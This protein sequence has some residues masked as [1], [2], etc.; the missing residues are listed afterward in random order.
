M[1]RWFEHAVLVIV[2]ILSIT[3]ISLF[4]VQYQTL[5]RAKSDLISL[6]RDTGSNIDWSDPYWANPYRS[7]TKYVT[8]DS[9]ENV[10]NRALACESKVDGCTQTQKALEEL[11]VTSTRYFALEDGV[12]LV[13]ESTENGPDRLY[14]LVSDARDGNQDV[15]GNVL[16]SFPVASHP[17]GDGGF[18][19]KR[20]SNG[21]YRLDV[22]ADYIEAGE[23]T[24]GYINASAKRFLTVSSASFDFG[25]TLRTP[26]I[27]RGVLEPHL[28]K[29]DCA[30]SSKATIDGILWNGNL[31]Y[32]F[33]K[34]IQTK[35]TYIEL[36]G[37]NIIDFFGQ[38]MVPPLN[39]SSIDIPLKT[40]G[41]L[42]VEF[43]GG[44]KPNFSLR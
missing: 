4:V 41:R 20:L 23:S 29:D 27:E 31:E 2:S 38:E 8:R 44:N 37:A 17:S 16:G 33:A 32:R 39:L 42:H 10:F 1:K 9:Y 7:P 24:T 40:G 11:T 15:T 3:F 28:S 14:R 6:Q 25:L 19:L 21:L 36:G 18:A 26:E 13:E 34:P 30:T 22:S 35:C 12:L 5:S 43:R